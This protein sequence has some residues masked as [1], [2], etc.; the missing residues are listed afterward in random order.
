MKGRGEGRIK[1]I[2]LDVWGLLVRLGRIVESGFLLGLGGL[3]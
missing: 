3:E 2:C 1:G